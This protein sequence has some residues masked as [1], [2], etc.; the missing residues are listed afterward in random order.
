MATPPTPDPRIKA[1][2]AAN[3]EWAHGPDYKPPI[4]FLEMQKKGRAREDGTVIVLACTDPRVC[5]ETFLGMTDGARATVVRTAGGRVRPALSTLYVLSAV[6]TEGKKGLIMVVHHTDCGLCHTTDEEIKESLR[7]RAS[8][9][10]EEKEVDAMVF[11][12]IS[13]PEMTV[14]EDV[15]ILRNSSF[16]RGIQIVGLVQ[17]TQTGVLKEVITV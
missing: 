3:L 9:P 4:P 12:S 5:P 14:K 6:G 11:G 15:E 8:G 10:E 17:D 1:Y 7:K 13:D 2:L 16:F